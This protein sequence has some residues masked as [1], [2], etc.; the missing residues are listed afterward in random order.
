MLVKVR[1]RA[2][3][4]VARSRDGRHPGPPLYFEALLHATI[5]YK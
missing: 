3:A 5:L 1:W 2:L 4:V